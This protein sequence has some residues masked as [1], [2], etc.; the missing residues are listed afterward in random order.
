[1]D[2]LIVHWGLALGAATALAS[3][4]RTLRQSPILA[5]IAVGLIGAR[6]EEW[7]SLPEELV[8]GMT[9]LGIV[10]LL[11]MAGLEVDMA[12]FLRRWKL[13]LIN[14]LG[15]LLLIG[16]I[17][18]GI[19]ALGFGVDTSG[20]AAFFGLCLALSSTILCLST[21][22]DRRAMES[23][24]GQI[25]LGMMVLQDIAAVASLSLLHSLSAGG[26]LLLAAI[27][28]AA[29][30]LL[31]AVALGALA[32]T[33]LPRVF[34]WFARA[35]EMLF[36]G[37]LGYCFSVAAAA[38]LLGLSAE[39]GAFFAGASLAF[40]PYRLEIEDKVD[41]LKT[42]GVI[43]FF[44]GLGFHLEFDQRVFAAA[45][46]IAGVV[47]FVVAG[48]LL[49][50]LALGALTGLASR[51]SFMIGAITN[52]ISEFSLILGTLCRQAGVFDDFQFA[53]L[54][55]AT[56]GT[57]VLSSAGHAIMDRVYD[58]TSTRLTFLD[59]RSIPSQIQHA[60][61]FSF[62]GHVVLLS[63]NEISQ[64]IA[65][66]FA[67]RG[68][69]VLLVDIDPDIHHHFAGTDGHNI[70]A[71]YADMVDPEV[72]EEFHFDKA[73]LIVSAM[74]D[75]QD[76]EIGLARW[77]RERNADVPFVAATA[78]HG[79]TLELYD[80]GGRYVIQTEQLAAERFREVLAAEFDRGASAAF[81]DVG[82]EHRGVIAALNAD[83][84][85]IGK[86]V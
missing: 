66:W 31:L 85:T 30:V 43:L 7:M 49:I 4:M 64:E 6:F 56:L 62:E 39:I 19:G 33:V 76:A 50:S 25:I 63:F 3:L 32:A 57:F 22:K 61:G 70:V 29:K 28:I 10:L 44:I 80:A 55:F 81:R 78:S 14:G 34:R 2:H 36:L 74:I 65:R 17:G 40:L 69:R 12:S 23:L 8:E 75:G 67:S 38:D 46:P 24:H 35:S 47:A 48:K 72:W 1:M 16:S 68:Q 42:F 83:L 26:S 11:F 79:E 51:P 45:V 13:V 27:A 71:V 86:L 73:S 77:L 58:I 9:H 41:P 15:Q 52:Q 53:V 59:R 20:G 84:G 18:A 37:A 60:A 5:F 82:R 54:T 21:L